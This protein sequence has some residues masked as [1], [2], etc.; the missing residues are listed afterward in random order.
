MGSVSF[1][2]YIISVRRERGLPTALF[3]EDGKEDEMENNRF[4]LGVLAVGL[5]GC[6]QSSAPA[7]SANTM[8][9]S[10]LSPGA[11]VRV[12]E[13]TEGLSTREVNDHLAMVFDLEQS[14]HELVACGGLVVSLAVA[15]IEVVVSLAEDPSGGLPWG[16]SREGGA[17]ISEPGGAGS[18]VMAARFFFGDDYE[19]GAE[20]DLVED[21]V[22]ALKSYLENP[23]LDFDYTTGEVLI[24]YDRRGPLV[25]LLGFGST[26]PRPLRLNVHNVGRLTREIEKLRIESTV[27]VDDARPNSSVVYE[28][29]SE[30]MA[31]GQLASGDGFDF[32]VVASSAWSDAPEQEMETR[33]WEVG[34]HNR[35]GGGLNGDIEFVVEGGAFAYQGLFEYQNDT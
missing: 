32:E 17:Y 16:L 30:S 25:E 28:I 27:V 2:P 22:F 14:Y 3:A 23:Q 11:E 5:G 24:R 8:L 21:N 9:G 20:G 4:A 34:F 26:P 33:V 12:Q 19:V 10:T 13:C 15:V 29:E 31:L 18:T 6:A 35:R 1:L 7:Q